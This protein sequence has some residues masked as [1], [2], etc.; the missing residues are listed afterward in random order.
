LK[1]AA[2]KT[3]EPWVKGVG[4]AN[5]LDPRFK[6]FF[7]SFCSQKEVLHFLIFRVFT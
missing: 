7:A 6:S 1:K 5:A 4:A 2:P 3:F